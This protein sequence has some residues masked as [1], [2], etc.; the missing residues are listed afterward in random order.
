MIVLEVP[1]A[2]FDDVRRRPAVMHHFAVESS[3]LVAGDEF[4][5]R[6]SG[7]HEQRC[8]CLGVDAVPPGRIRKNRRVMLR[9]Q[10]VG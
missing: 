9:F 7:R 4:T 8:V 2:L 5:I 10:P 1:R 6:S 3:D